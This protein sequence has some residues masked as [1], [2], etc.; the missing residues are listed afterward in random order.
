MAPADPYQVLSPA[1][2]VH[3]VASVCS[4]LPDGLTLRTQGPPLSVDKW[5]TAGN[6]WSTLGVPSYRILELQAYM[7]PTGLGSC[8]ISP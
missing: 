2:P 1:T 3:P 8:V 5:T 6:P 4:I 7:M